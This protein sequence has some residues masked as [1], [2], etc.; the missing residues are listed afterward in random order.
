MIYHVEKNTFTCFECSSPIWDLNPGP[1]DI[2]SEAL[3][4]D[5]P[6]NE[7]I[8]FRYSKV[9]HMEFAKKWTKIS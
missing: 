6:V 5:I 8:L 2:R 4:A 1:P 7:T 9:K 3:A